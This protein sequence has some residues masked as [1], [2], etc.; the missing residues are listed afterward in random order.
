MLD[1]LRET[2]TPRGLELF[3][4]LIVNEEPPSAVMA[5]TGL[6]RDAIYQW[7]ARLLHAL[8]KVAAELDAPPMSENPSGLRTGKGAPRT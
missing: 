5:A 8:R 7:K 3:Q 6:S 2:L 4:R 1:R